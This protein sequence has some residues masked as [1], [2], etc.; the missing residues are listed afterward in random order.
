MSLVTLYIHMYVKYDE[1]DFLLHLNLSYSEH[2]V[3]L[4][5]MERGNI[6]FSHGLSSLEEGRIAENVQLGLE[7][8]GL[9]YHQEKCEGCII[10]GREH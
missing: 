6:I 5:D 10:S 7:P 4:Q 8:L 2:T 9:C 3:N 1:E